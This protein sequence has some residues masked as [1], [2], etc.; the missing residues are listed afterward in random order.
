M[1]TRRAALGALLLAVTW[2]FAGVEACGGGVTTVPGT[3]T[4][5]GSPPA[6]D[7]PASSAD[8]A[9]SS[10]DAAHG[11]AATP[12]ATQHSEAGPDVVVPPDPCAGVKLTFQPPAGTTFQGAGD[13]TITASASFPAGGTIFY[14]T[15]GTL[16]THASNVYI[17]PI[18]LTASATIFAIATAPGCEDAPPF[19]AAY[20]VASVDAGSAP[21]AAAQD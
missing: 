19:Q 14:T 4:D 18:H 8:G 1:T 20:T 21:D 5:S 3:A 6:A 11:D 17:G 16:P 13:V 10:V 7:G 2:C 9:G 12:D 15:N